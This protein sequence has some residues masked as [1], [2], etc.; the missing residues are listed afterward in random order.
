MI[1]LRDVASA[2]RVMLFKMKHDLVIEKM[3]LDRFF[4][5]FLEQY[6][7]DEE[8]LDTPEWHTYRE[9]TKEYDRIDRL[10]KTADFYIKQNA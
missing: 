5:V 9:M 10:L 1:T 2:D 8:N 4:S 6:E 7:M 3:K